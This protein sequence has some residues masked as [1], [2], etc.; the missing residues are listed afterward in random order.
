V[1]I[2]GETPEDAA[3]QIVDHINDVLTRTITRR[4]V[5]SFYMP[6]RALAHISFPK[7][8]N[9][10]STAARLDTR[11]GPMRFLFWQIVGGKAGGRRL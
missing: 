4:R 1:A 8:D 3:D 2:V 6:D 9:G 7:K 11:F 5:D 10:S